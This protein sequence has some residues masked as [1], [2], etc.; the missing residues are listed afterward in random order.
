MR[1]TLLPNGK[2]HILDNTGFATEV[3][4]EHPDYTSLCSQ[5]RKSIS[6]NT[7]PRRLGGMAAILVGIAGWW[8]N[9]HLLIT[10]HQYYRG[11]VLLGPLGLFGGLLL[12]LRPEWAEPLRSDSSPAHK[13]ALI[14]V[15]ILMATAVGIDFYLLA[16]Y[17]G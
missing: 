9:W 17:R 2:L 8:Y 14:S 16:H 15:A 6:P 7:V 4:P 10:E 5:Y 3:C 12:L 13:T 1:V 11:L